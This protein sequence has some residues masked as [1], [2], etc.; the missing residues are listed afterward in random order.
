MVEKP[1][2]WLLRESPQSAPPLH[3]SETSSSASY[4]LKESI[5]YMPRMIHKATSAGAI[6]SPVGLV[7]RYLPP[8]EIARYQYQYHNQAAGYRRVSMSEK[9]NQPFNHHR[10][11]Y[12]SPSAVY[13][14]QHHHHRSRLTPLTPPPQPQ[15]LS[16]PPS[17]DRIDTPPCVRS[18]TREFNKSIDKDLA[19][20]SGTTTT[21]QQTTTATT[22]VSMPSAV[23]KMIRNDE[24]IHH[25]LQQR[26]HQ[27]LYRPYT[28]RHL[29]C[30]CRSCYLKYLEEAFAGGHDTKYRHYNRHH[31]HKETIRRGDNEEVEQEINEELWLNQHMRH[32][33]SAGDAMMASTM[34]MNLS[35]RTSPNLANVK[36]EDSVFVIDQS[37]LED[38]EGEEEEE[39]NSVE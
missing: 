8:G 27:F 16:R 39:E 2:S 5:T 34:M 13:K 11:H 18:P 31:Y 37:S 6:S 22:T 12:Q 4:A 15:P 36:M 29:P 25:K 32:S 3:P 19:A 7:P 20:S 28:P 24:D 10:H 23:R 17:A 1:S 26:Q 14:H 30:P 33:N 38:E 35:P 9:G 21:E